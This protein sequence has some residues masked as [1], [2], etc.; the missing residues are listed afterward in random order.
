V[1]WGDNVVWGDMLF[2]GTDGSGFN[3]VW[4]D[5]VVWGD[6]AQDGFNVVWGDAIYSVVRLQGSDVDDGD[7]DY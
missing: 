4:G 5:T 1:V 3:V 6:I 7:Q 2:N